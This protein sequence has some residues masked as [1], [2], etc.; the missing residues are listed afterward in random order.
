MKEA[1][2]TSK[3]VIEIYAELEQHGLRIWV[4][5]GW[6]VDALIGKES[7]AHKDLDIAIQ[8]KDV[9]QLREILAAKGYGQ[10][11]EDSEW[12]FVLGDDAGHEID[13]HVFVY[14]AQGN[15][16]DGI[17]YPAASLTGKGVINEHPVRCI[18]PEYVVKF[19]SGYELKETDFRDVRAICEKFDIPLPDEYD[20][21]KSGQ[22]QQS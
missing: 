20:R 19:H 4:D 12:N 7:R 15:V 18:A 5:G 6:G 8:R 17:M 21:F 14:D 9:S 2:V 1:K 11:R 3:D 10:V 13:V 22:C 16:V